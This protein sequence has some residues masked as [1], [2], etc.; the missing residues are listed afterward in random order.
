MLCSTKILSK[1]IVLIDT[2]GI[3]ST[4]RHNTEVTLN[5]LPQCDAALFL[6]S[7]DPP[8][9]EVEVEFLKH[10]KTKVSLI[11]FILNKIDYLDEEE[12]QKV[13]N[14]FKQV[15]KEQAGYESDPIIFSVQQSR[16]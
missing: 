1:G 9:T 5:F 13:L 8:I 6:V 14:F 15:L 10:L 3:G 11:F 12:R 16:A 2:P 4:F 7:A